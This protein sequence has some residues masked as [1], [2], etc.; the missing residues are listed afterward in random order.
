MTENPKENLEP[1]MLFFKTL[2]DRPLNPPSLETFVEDMDEIEV[3]DKN[4]RWKIKGMAAKV[5]YRLFSKYGNPKFVD[6]N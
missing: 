6:D 1:W 2:L 5:T 4:I 3:R